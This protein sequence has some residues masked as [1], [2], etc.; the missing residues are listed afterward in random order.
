ML[1]AQ[2]SIAEHLIELQDGFE[3]RRKSIHWPAAILS[4]YR[5][6]DMNTTGRSS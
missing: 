1:R 3:P 6:V 5:F 2:N 4:D